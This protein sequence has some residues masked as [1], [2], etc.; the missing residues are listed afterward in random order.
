VKN[1]SIQSVLVIGLGYV[2]LPLLSLIAK[3]KKDYKSLYKAVGFDIDSQ[4]IDSIKTLECNWVDEA[5]IF[6]LRENKS[7]WQV[8]SQTSQFD[9]KYDYILICVP[10]PVDQQDNPDLQAVIKAGKAAADLIEKDGVIILES[11][12]NPGVCDE[13]LRPAIVE[14]LAK[15]GLIYNQ[16]VYLAHCPERI[17]PGNNNYPLAKIPRVLGASSEIGLQKS[18]N[19]YKSILNAPVKPVSSLAAAEAVKIVENTFRDVNIAFVN[20]LAQSF[21]KLDLNVVEIIDAA[22]TK[23]FGFLAHYPGAGVG[24]HCIPVDPYYLISAAGKRGFEHKFLKLARE[25]NR[26]MP[27]FTVDLLKNELNKLLVDQKKRKS[28]IKVALLG[29]SYKANVADLRNSPA[30]EIL[31]LLQNIPEIEVVAYDPLINN[32]ISIQEVSKISLAESLSDLQADTDVKAVLIATAH[33]EFIDSFAQNIWPNLKLIV[34]GRNCLTKWPV[35]V[36]YRG[37]GR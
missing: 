27:S 34:D 36:T 9:Q 31:K 12:V 26:S 30:L 1:D 28:K 20:E 33:S 35:G 19:F 3:T 2:G 37:I 24:G 14:I 5:T 23:P 13:V 11:T 6:D 25:I 29:L 21:S 8:F 15:R 32:G 10:T 17:D 22:A 16:D 7:N 4:K 18:L